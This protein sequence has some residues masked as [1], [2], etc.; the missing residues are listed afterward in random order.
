MSDRPKILEA[1]IR[2]ALRLVDPVKG[3][4]WI[5]EAKEALARKRGGQPKIDPAE[6]RRLAKTLGVT[7]A[8]EELGV[9]RQTVHNAIKQK[10]G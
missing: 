9:S 3:A 5:A 2:K 6:A 7:G 8:A 1:L 10:K 4:D